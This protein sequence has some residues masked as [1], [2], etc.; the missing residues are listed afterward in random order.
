MEQLPRNGVA[1]LAMERLHRLSGCERNSPMD[2]PFISCL[3]GARTENVTSLCYLVGP[4]WDS[5]TKVNRFILNLSS[6]S[7]R[8]ALVTFMGSA[9]S[10]FPSPSDLTQEGKMS[11]LKRIAITSFFLSSTF[12]LAQSIPASEANSH[13][14]ERTTICGTIAKTHTSCASRGTP[15][16]ID[17]DR[18]YPG[19][20]F[21]AVVWQHDRASVGTLPRADT[22]C[23]SGIITEYR[24]RPQLVLHSASQWSVPRTHSSS[25]TESTTSQTL[26]NNQ[27]YTN[28]EGR[29]VHSP[30]YSSAGPPAGASAQCGDGTYSF[31][32]HRQG[33][34]SHHDSVARWL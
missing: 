4:T 7:T 13:I 24:G 34:C 8:K 23:V 25:F 6:P 31:S 11:L 30:A 21:T 32:Q 33:T 27:H 18:L 12:A 22:L 16:F 15:T 17:F 26:S 2:V 9:A 14:G 5:G 29:T 20:T 3:G 28:V 1:P 19:E 10:V